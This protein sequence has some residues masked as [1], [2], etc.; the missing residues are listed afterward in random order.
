MKRNDIG[1]KSH[2]MS[3]N[4]SN[5]PEALSLKRAIFLRRKNKH[6]LIYDEVA[7]RARPLIEHLSGSNDLL[8]LLEVGCGTGLFTAAVVRNISG[9]TFNVEGWDADAKM[10]EGFHRDIASPNVRSAKFR[11]VDLNEA[12][13]SEP[14]AAGTFHI[15]L[16][17]FSLYHFTAAL[18]RLAELMADAGIGIFLT[19]SKD[20][21]SA[22]FEIWREVLQEEFGRPTSQPTYVE[23]IYNSFSAENAQEMLYPWF[24]IVDRFYFPSLM[25]F[26][27]DFASGVDLTLYLLQ[28]W[29]GRLENDVPPQASVFSLLPKV[30][31]R[32]EQIIAHRGCYQVNKSDGCFIVS[33]KKVPQ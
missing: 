25:S 12:I 5:C 1:A 21:L 24:E 14:E 31:D 23:G 32:V 26:T 18:P 28:K 6:S 19:S 8:S 22:F 3:E 30:L 10:A 33:K 20:T 17:S 4:A 15:L 9:K 27:N 13:I 29:R 11:T 16:S 7:V 2:S